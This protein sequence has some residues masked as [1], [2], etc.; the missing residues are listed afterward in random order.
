MSCI[1]I[2]IPHFN[3]SHLIQRLLNSIPDES[4]INVYVVDDHSNK[5]HFG[6]LMERCSSYSCVK[7]LKVPEGLKGPGVARN[8]GLEK[9]SSKWLLFADVDDYFTASAF[10]EIKKVLESSVDIV[11]FQPTSEYYETKKLASRHLH[12]KYLFEQ[13]HKDHDSKVFYRFFAPWSKMISRNLVEMHG[14][15]FD[16]GIG[17]EDNNFSLKASF[18]ANSFEINES[19]IYCIV[20]SENSMTAHYSTNVLANHFDSMCRYNDFLQAHN[21]KKYQASMLG[22]V[23]RGRQISL[24]TM[25]KWGWIS[26]RKGYPLSLLNHIK[27]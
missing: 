24:S 27:L 26:L 25:F 14:I 21:Q 7:V 1:D 8:I 2:I 19:C 11:Y 16:D 6:F 4:W 18:F 5:E 13:Y 3:G 10:S 22:W 15:Q 9:S 23:F 12:Y 17:G 20:D